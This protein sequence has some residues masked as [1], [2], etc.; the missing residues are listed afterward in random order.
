MHTKSLSA[1]GWGYGSLIYLSKN[2]PKHAYSALVHLRGLHWRTRHLN[3]CLCLGWTRPAMPPAD[4]R[5][6]H[7][8]IRPCFWLQHRRHW[9][10]LSSSRSCLQHSC[11]ENPMDA[12]AWWAAVHWVAKSWT[13]L[14]WLHFDFSLSC[15][16]EGNCTPLQCS[17]LENPRDRGT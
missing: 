13:R 9:P 10:L 1:A 16:G 2:K 6:L 5:A 3:L 4:E 15:I 8:G 11:L 14:E 12:G 17:C 7:L